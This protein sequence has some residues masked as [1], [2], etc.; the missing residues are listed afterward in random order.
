MLI[1]LIIILILLVFAFVITPLLFQACAKLYRTHNVNF[2]NALL[3]SI[4]ASLVG[5]FFQSLSYI[6]KIE[7][8]WFNTIVTIISLVIIIWIV[9]RRFNT[10]FLKTIGIYFTVLILSVVIALSI[11]TFLVQAFK[12]PSG[13]MLETIQIGDH[14]LVNKCIYNFKSPE[15]GDIIVF[16]YVKDPSIDYLS[17]IIAVAGDSI[18]IKDKSVFINNDLVDE[19]YIIHGDSRIFSSDLSP[20]DNFGPVTVPENS[21][22]VM[23][24]NRD[25]SNDSRFW[26]FVDLKNIRGKAFII[27]WSLDKE[28]GTSRLG[29]IGKSL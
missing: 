15:R 11:R 14:L 19:P 6:F 7:I 16:A 5:L 2:K 4:Y 18:E 10:T 12:I 21:C 20:R 26:G 3:T 29:R 24:D 1:I 27:Y 9:K 13:S 25:N 17:R 22:F 23:G 8:L 28:K